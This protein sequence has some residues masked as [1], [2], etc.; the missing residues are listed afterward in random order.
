MPS[1]Q[2]VHYDKLLT[3]ISVAYKNDQYIADQILKEVPVDKQ[4]DKYPV[5][6]EEI[7]VAQD[8]RRAPEQKLMKSIGHTVTIH[9]SVKDMLSVTGFLTRLSRTQTRLSILKRKPLF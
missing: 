5:Y 6:G 7:F 4:S 3:N 2:S 8:D 9:T 1:V